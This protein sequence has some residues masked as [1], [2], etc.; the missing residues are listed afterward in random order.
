MLTPDDMQIYADSISNIY[1]NLED[2]IF[3]LIVQMLLKSRFDKIDQTNILLWQVEQLNK[4]GVLNDKVIDL[5][6]K[7]SHKTSKEI[8]QLIIGNGQKIVNEIDRELERMIHR[9]V[10]VSKEVDN[11]LDSFV[12]QTFRD[13]N[14]NINQTLI[15]TNFSENSV[16]RTYQAILK[17]STLE[18]MTGLK[19]HDQAIRDNIYKMVDVGIKSS[20]I[21]KAGH[22]WSME[23]YSRMVIQS[24]SHR[25]FNDLRL[26]RMDD[27]DCVTALMSSHPAAR[28]ACAYIQGKVVNIVPMSDPRA[29]KRYDSIYNHGYGDPSGTQGIGC[30]HLL[31]PFIPDVNT[32]NQP[33]QAPEEAIANAEIQQQQRKLE[34]DIRCQKKRL[35]VAKELND[36]MTIKNCTEVIQNK[37]KQIRKLID[38]HD[39]LVRDYSREQVYSR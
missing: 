26:K 35:N 25:T 27:H 11:I 1:S 37:Q 17:K 31:H 18:T 3:T 30:K 5:L 6:A 10:P 13:L 23:A 33:E 32:N 24:T 16:M 9:S 29:D 36:D 8:E 22:E 7:I 21:D 20:F 34:R 2:R 12:R 19:T 4:M 39:F 15:T 28:K 14:N 38:K